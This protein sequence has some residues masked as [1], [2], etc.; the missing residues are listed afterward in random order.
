MRRVLVTCTGVLLVVAAC[1]ESTLTLVP[2]RNVVLVLLDTVRA[3]RL[4][5]YGNARDTT[6]TIDALAARGARFVRAQSAAPW[7]VPSVATLWTGTL[8]STH[9]AGVLAE[10]DEPK[11]FAGKGSFRG[12]DESALPTLPAVL[13]ARGYRTFGFVA[14]P[15]L[16]GLSCFLGGFERVAVDFVKAEVAVEQALEWLDELT[17]SPPFFLYLQLMDAHQPLDPRHRYRDLYPTDGGSREDKRYAAWGGMTEPRDMDSEAIPAFRE[18]RL[19]IYDGALRYMDD[20]LA[21]LLRALEERDLLASTLVIVTSDHGEEFWD[22]GRAQLELYDCKARGTVG[23]GHGQSQ[24]Q[25]LLAVPLVLAGPGLEPREISTPVSLLDLP[26]TILELAG[27]AAPPTLGQSQSLVPLLRGG[28]ATRRA[29]AAEETSVGF[30]LKSLLRA[31]GLKYIRSERPGEKEAL[32]D[33]TLDPLEQRN[34]AT[35]RP[36]EA[37]ALRAEL[38]ELIEAA[39]A[40]R[41]EPGAVGQASTDDLEA[42]GYGGESREEA[43]RP[44]QP[45]EPRELRRAVRRGERRGR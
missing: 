14:N 34:L 7:T 23:V 21:R 32:F 20:Q 16:D 25:E 27:G 8:P 15:V 31:D 36:E 29:L 45:S 12:F 5:S 6:P 40:R 22:H 37:A 13:A 18:T 30:E 3:D 11:A 41:A 26:A 44:P 24:F 1:G 2:P 19:A 42:L 10:A 28:E 39:L 43:T 38:E 33:L 17:E 9:G 4:S 35:A